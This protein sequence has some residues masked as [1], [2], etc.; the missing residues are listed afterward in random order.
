MSSNRVDGVFAPSW[1]WGMNETIQLARTSQNHSDGFLHHI[2][3]YSCLSSRYYAGFGYHSP[4]KR[5]SHHSAYSSP[6]GHG[7]RRHKYHSPPPFSIGSLCCH[8]FNYAGCSSHSSHVYL[9]DH[10][11]VQ[12]IVSE[13]LYLWAACLVVHYSYVI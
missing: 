2:Q 7:W 13:D 10:K 8:S 9:P 5:N 6:P 3:A 12:P 4:R 1:V 11:L